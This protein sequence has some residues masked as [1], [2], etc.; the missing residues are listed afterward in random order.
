M[1]IKLLLILLLV[2]ALKSWSQKT[3]VA[4]LPFEKVASFPAESDAIY[5]K[6]KQAFIAT[7]RFEIVDR[8]NFEK[9]NSEKELQK[10]ENF[11]NSDIVAQANAKG[12]EQLVT[13]RVIY[14]NYT[15]H[16]TESS[17]Y[18]DCNISF[19]L[20]VLDVETGQVIYSATLKPEDSFL[21]SVLKSSLGGNN[22]QAK[23]FDNS[24]I[25]MQKYIDAFIENY[26][27]IHT[28]ILEIVEI[29]KEEAKEVL[30]NVG[31]QTGTQKNDKYSVI[32]ITTYEAGGKSIKREVEIGELKVTDVQGA[33]ISSAK[34]SKGGEAILE[35]FQS[36]AK[37]LCKSKI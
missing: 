21:N 26:F 24:L 7:N 37:L 18:Y 6:V 12:A 14:V 11:L 29:K 28:Q 33:E 15:K 8:K 9:I 16:T 4:L 35:K 23:A 17:F 32:E 10:T 22:T 36:N 20:D 30:L 2:M 34:V 25:R 5:E 1:K 3:T 19:S 13:G 27:P 31:T